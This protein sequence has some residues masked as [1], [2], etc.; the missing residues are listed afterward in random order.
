FFRAFLN[1]EFVKTRFGRRE[2]DTVRFIVYPFLRPEHTDE[3]ID[4]IIVRCYVIIADGPIVS[5]SINAPTFEVVRT[6][7]KRYASP[8][9]CPSAKHPGTEPIELGS[10]LVCVGLAFEFPSA[11]RCIEVAKVTIGCTRT[12]SRRFPRPL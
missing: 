4:S 8:V 6:K 2:E 9:D 7:S 11:V 10:I 1:E 3:A 12:S 5:K